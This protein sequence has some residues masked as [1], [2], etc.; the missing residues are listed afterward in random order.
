MG[1]WFE[2]AVE[3]EYSDADELV[4]EVLSTEE[5][6]LDTT[7]VTA[8]PLGGRLL[9]HHHGSGQREQRARTG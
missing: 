2:R 5:D 8:C 7:G 6:G 1:N 3:A 9:T 4:A